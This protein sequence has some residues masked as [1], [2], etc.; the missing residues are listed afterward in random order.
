MVAAFVRLRLPSRVH[1]P[2]L[3]K[4]HL[5]SL[6]SDFHIHTYHLGCANETMTLPAIVDCLRE[7]GVTQFGIADHLNTT[8]KLPLHEKIKDDITALPQGDGSMELYFGVELNFLSC[9][10]DFAYDED[11][12]DKT[13]F[14]FAIGGIHGTYVDEYDINKIVEIQHRHH[15]LTCQHPLVDVVVHPWWFSKRPFDD[16]GWP[17]FDDMSVVPASMTRELGQVAAETGTAI[18]INA[19]AIIICPNYSD[20]FKEQYVDYLAVLAE[21]G[22]KFSIGSDAHSRDHFAGL[23]R[24]VEAARAAGITEDMIWTPAGE[25]FRRV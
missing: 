7:Q 10:G 13:G 4:D 6:Q 1:G 3:R 12:R 24:A 22:C 19:A 11:I 5:M 21:T 16:K 14:Q 9:D 8:D 17:W 25:P 20:R 15:L 2:G 18:E 23:P